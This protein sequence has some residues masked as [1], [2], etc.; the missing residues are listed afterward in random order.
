MSLANQK[1]CEGSYEEMVVFNL[2]VCHDNLPLSCYL[3]PLELLLL[4]EQSPAQNWVICFPQLGNT[5]HSR[6]VCNHSTSSSEA[7]NMANFSL[8]ETCP[9]NSSRETRNPEGRTKKNVKIKT[10]DWTQRGGTKRAK[11]NLRKFRLSSNWRCTP[12]HHI[13]S[14]SIKVLAPS[15]AQKIEISNKWNNNSRRHKRKSFWKSFWAAIH[16]TNRIPNF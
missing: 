8:W 11:K 14:Q 10:G 4:P 12:S 13:C 7:V 5:S 2:Q 3:E 1:T 15:K 9:C 6:Y 16:L